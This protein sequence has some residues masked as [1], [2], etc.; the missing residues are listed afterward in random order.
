[1]SRSH[2]GSAPRILSND[3]G[4][5]DDIGTG[6][7]AWLRA[8]AAYP[9]GAVVTLAAGYISFHGL[10]RLAGSVRTLNR[11]GVPVRILFGV[12]PTG[13]A[14]VSYDAE[15]SIVRLRR[16][17]ADGEDALDEELEALDVSSEAAAQLADLVDVL[18]DPLV[19]VRR[20]ERGSSTPRRSW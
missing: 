11:A 6:L 7:D 1:M 2:P 18:R 13:S 12:A 8:V 5:G 17:L 19:Q 10:M 16:L 4:E 15:E 20:Y 3:D 14:A 9:K